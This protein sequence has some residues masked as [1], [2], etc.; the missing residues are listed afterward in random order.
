MFNDPALELLTGEETTQLTKLIYKMGRHQQKTGLLPRSVFFAI[1]ETMPIAGVDLAVIRPGPVPE[2]LLAVRPAEDPFF[3]GLWHIPGTRVLMG[4][5]ALSAIVKRV[6]QRDFGFVLPR[7]P[8][9]LAARDIMKG[10]AGP[11]S[12][13]AGQ[14]IYRSFGYI[15][16][17][18]DQKIPTSKD[19]DFF[20]LNRIPVD[21]IQHQLPTIDHLR[22]LHGV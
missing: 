5:D 17:S 12:S 18:E 11:N 2:L 6:M 1:T 20:P 21:F 16:D 8:E 14:E 19:M 13:P 7:E 10:P 9:F 3:A 15:L 4:D 22:V